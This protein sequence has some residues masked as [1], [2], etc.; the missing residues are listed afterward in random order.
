MTAE[1]RRIA[2]SM[3]FSEALRSVTGQIGEIE[4]YRNTRI[5][6]LIAMPPLSA[7]HCSAA[8]NGR[9]LTRRAAWARYR[10]AALAR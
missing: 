5:K 9:T 8:T 7:K 1:I 4:V 6:R 2:A 10:S 3:A